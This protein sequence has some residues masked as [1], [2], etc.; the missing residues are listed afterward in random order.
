MSVEEYSYKPNL[1]RLSIA[2]VAFVGMAFGLAD[3]ARHNDRGLIIDV[4]IRLNA[5][6]AT[7]FY[8]ALSILCFLFAV[9]GIFAV[10][11]KRH[12]YS[13]LR[14]TD[15]ELVIVPASREGDANVIPPKNIIL[16]ADIQKMTLQT[17]YHQTFLTVYHKGGKLSIVEKW[18]TTKADFADFKQTL[19]QRIG[20]R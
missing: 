6:E 13:L 1:V 4:I 11:V 3:I 15:K 12:R 5:H 8:W 20:A 16:L 7:L 18:F 19:V 2:L 9:A 14:L 10:F 17:I